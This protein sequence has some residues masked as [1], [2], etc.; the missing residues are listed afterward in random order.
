MKTI[1]L[2]GGM[3]AESSAEY[4]RIINQVVRER[5][6]GIHSGKI[7]M[8][9]VDFGEIE[10]L[11]DREDWERITVILIN[12][13][14]RLER[15]GADL[16][17]LCTNTMHKLA[18]PIQNAIHIPLLSIIEVTAKRIL[19]AELK[20]AGL[21]G[22]RFTM[23]GDFYRRPLEEKFGIKTIIPEKEDREKIHR[24]IVEELSIG[25]IENESRKTYLRIM[26]KLRTRGAEGVILGCTE[27]PLLVQAEHT[28]VPLFDTTRLHAEAAVQQAL[29]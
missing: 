17:L 27:I 20:T 19:D 1:G 14:L 12:A 4:Y 11:M 29:G 5:L 16:L 23:E 24:I 28:E 10:P 18:E 9:S 13:A 15:A 22:T 2:L 7:I 3:T 21:L 8:Y 6:G 26:E 25:K